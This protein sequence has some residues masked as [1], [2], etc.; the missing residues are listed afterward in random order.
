[1]S[2][3]D[4]IWHGSG[5]QNIFIYITVQLTVLRLISNHL[6]DFENVF[7]VAQFAGFCE[8]LIAEIGFIT[9]RGGI[10]SHLSSRLMMESL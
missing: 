3:E 9:T 6:N 4:H 1:M 5:I 8:V 7:A 2:I 10:V